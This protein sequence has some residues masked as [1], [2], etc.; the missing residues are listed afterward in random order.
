MADMTPQEANAA[1]LGWVDKHNPNYGKTG[2]VGSTPGTSGAGNA[3]GSASAAAGV[4][5]A[6]APG[7]KNPS[8]SPTPALQPSPAPQGPTPKLR[9]FVGKRIESSLLSI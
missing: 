6:V 9:K 8:P 5:G 2:F 3:G 7:L 4:P 1:G